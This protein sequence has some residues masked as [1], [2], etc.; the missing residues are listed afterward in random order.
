MPMIWLYVFLQDFL[1]PF[2]CDPHLQ[3]GII[4]LGIQASYSIIPW[5]PCYLAV[6]YPGIQFNLTLLS[7]G[8]HAI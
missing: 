1:I 4:A 5:Y 2:L 8:I 6:L 7:P 3:C